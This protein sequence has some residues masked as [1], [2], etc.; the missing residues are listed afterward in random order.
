MENSNGR[1]MVFRVV[2]YLYAIMAFIPLGI[3]HVFFP[4][5]Y[6]S[7]INYKAWN[8]NDPGQREMVE[9]VGAFFIAQSLGA[10]RVGREPLR[11]RDLFLVL[12][13]TMVMTAVVVGY[14]I[15]IGVA[16]QVVWFNTILP[17]SI[18]LIIMA[19]CYPWREAVRYGR[20]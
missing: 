10:W 5:Q 4:D 16:P 6:F 14:T 12:M 9:L 18:M 1:L 17:Y 3:M 7:M 19:F 2:I 13:A 15:T 20:K 8:P 11:N